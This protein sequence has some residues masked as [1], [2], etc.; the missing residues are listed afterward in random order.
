MRTIAGVLTTAF[1]VISCSPTSTDAPPQAQPIITMLAAITTDNSDLLKTV[2]SDPQLDDS[3]TEPDRDDGLKELKQ[4][5][6]AFYRTTDLD[7]KAFRY[8]YIGN[9]EAGQ[10]VFTYR[11]KFRDSI[12]VVKEGHHWKISGGTPGFN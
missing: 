7:L 6:M 5:V 8:E 2:L 1:L 9:D 10:V 12:D 3:S 11:G 4:Q